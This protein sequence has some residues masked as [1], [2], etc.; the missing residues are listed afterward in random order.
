MEKPDYLGRFT[1][2][3]VRA[4]LDAAAPIPPGNVHVTKNR[5]VSRATAIVMRLDRLDETIQP[6]EGQVPEVVDL[7]DE[8]RFYE[9][10]PVHQDLCRVP[11]ALRR[12]GADRW[13][14]CILAKA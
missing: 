11:I 7:P 9:R 1:S 13:A 14:R 5:E 4:V 6:I 10:C 12:L 2:E 8:C 3:Q